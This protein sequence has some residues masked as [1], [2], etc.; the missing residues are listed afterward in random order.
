MNDE[1]VSSGTFVSPINNI[2]SQSSTADSGR[3]TLT[4]FLP[5]LQSAARGQSPPL[6]RRVAAV[7]G[8]W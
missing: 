4:P 3:P 1:I 2:K 6:P 8:R 7:L 5:I